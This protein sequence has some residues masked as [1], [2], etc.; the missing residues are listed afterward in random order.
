M[1]AR[2]D[3]DHATPTLGGRNAKRHTSS[4]PCSGERTE[5]LT[6]WGATPPR[7]DARLPSGGRRAKQM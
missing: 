6:T 3:A 1:A 2:P 7:R 5:T 4:E